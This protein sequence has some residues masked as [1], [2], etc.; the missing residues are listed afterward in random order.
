MAIFFQ[1]SLALASTTTA[2]YPDTVEKQM[3]NTPLA[4]GWLRYAGMGK[5]DQC[6]IDAGESAR[7][8]SISGE[9]VERAA[10]EFRP[11]WGVN[12]FAGECRTDADIFLG[13]Y[14]LVQLCGSRN[15]GKFAA[16]VSVRGDGGDDNAGAAMLDTFW[17]VQ[18]L[19][20][21]IGRVFSLPRSERLSCAKTALLKWE[22][23]N[24]STPKNPFAT[25]PGFFRRFWD[26]VGRL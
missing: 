8:L 15:G 3:L 22:S 2:R 18:G 9:W 12:V 16:A 13:S 6:D 20:A 23:M 26:L 4:A 24:R 1:Y 21:D 19:A 11:K 5:I 17:Q 10:A 25:K 7:L 14:L